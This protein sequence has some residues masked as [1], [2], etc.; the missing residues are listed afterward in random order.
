MTEITEYIVKDGIKHE[1]FRIR[2]KKGQLY[3]KIK[4]ICEYCKK[5][6]FAQIHHPGRFCS[7][8]CRGKVCYDG[9]S[10][11][12]NRWL[13]FKGDSRALQIKSHSYIYNLIRAKKITRPDRCSYCGMSCSPVFHHPNS[14]KFNEGNWLCRSCHDKVHHG[15]KIEV[16][17]VVFPFPY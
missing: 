5:E 6:I 7:N 11:N 8:Y 14:K 3:K 17:L 15:H 9:K 1:I 2:N 13:L 10:M 4:R 12:K 16:P